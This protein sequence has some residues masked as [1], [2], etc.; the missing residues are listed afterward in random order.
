VL[1]V[2]DEGAVGV[3]GQGGLARAGQAEEQGHAGGVVLGHVA[4]AVHREHALL[5]HVEVHGVEDALLHLAGV[6]GAED[7]HDLLLERLGD[8]DRA[9]QAQLRL[10]L[11][12]QLV[13]RR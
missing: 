8:E 6:L 11:G 10:L 5:G 4:R 7:D 1:V 2:A 13:R 9:L 3:G 12:R